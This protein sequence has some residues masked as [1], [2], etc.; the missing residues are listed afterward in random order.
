MRC[1]LQDETAAALREVR[2]FQGIW[3]DNE[4]SI[5][6][7]EAAGVEHDVTNGERGQTDGPS[8]LLYVQLCNA[9]EN[10]RKRWKQQIPSVDDTTTVSYYRLWRGEPHDSYHTLRGRRVAAIIHGMI[11]VRRWPGSEIY[12]VS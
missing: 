1:N 6:G 5:G 7:I 11:F 12:I 2:Y 8:T 10:M 3:S 9:Q 4:R